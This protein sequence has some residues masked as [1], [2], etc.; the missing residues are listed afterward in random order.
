MQ[1]SCR[2]HSEPASRRAL[3]RFGTTLVAVIMSG[4]AVAFDTINPLDTARI[5]LL[6]VG[7]SDCAPCRSWQRE[8]GA[9]FRQS[10]AFSRLSY[11]EVRSP[12]LRDVL[13]D[14]NWPV[15]LRR[16]RDRLGRDAGVPLWF[17]ILDGSVIVEG[18]GETQWNDRI[19]PRIRMLAR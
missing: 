15:D 19:L 1:W 11:R 16:Y 14:A 4:M 13:D 6:Y 9:R 12:H 5:T 8:S 3:V 18:F 17:V 7:A 2:Q 10:D